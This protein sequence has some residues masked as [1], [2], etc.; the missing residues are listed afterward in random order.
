[1][2]SLIAER[3]SP[4]VR[5]KIK[6]GSSQGETE[7]MWFGESPKRIWKPAVVRKNKQAAYAEGNGFVVRMIL[8]KGERRTENA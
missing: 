3:G 6:I 1:V 8:S 7:G 5:K 2:G 4:R